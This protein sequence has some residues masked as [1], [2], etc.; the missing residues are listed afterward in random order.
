MSPPTNYGDVANKGPVDV[1]ETLAA[2]QTPDP[3]PVQGGGARLRG[4]AGNSGWQTLCGDHDRRGRRGLAGADWSWET[5]R[6]VSGARVYQSFIPLS[7]VF[8]VGG[9]PLGTHPGWSP[10]LWLQREWDPLQQHKN[11]LS[12]QKGKVRLDLDCSDRVVSL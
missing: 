4:L 1:A 11:V 6:F 9:A 10:S 3:K 5:N 12:T 2:P 7:C 8:P